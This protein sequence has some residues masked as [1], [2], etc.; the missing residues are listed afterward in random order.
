MNPRLGAQVTVREFAFDFERGA[1]DSRAFAGLQVGDFSLETAPLGPSQIHA[2]EH[3][4]PILRLHPASARMNR[5][6]RAEAIELAAEHYLELALAKFFAR[7]VKRGRRLARSLAVFLAVLAAFGGGF[8]G[9]YLKEKAR[10]LEA[11]GQTLKRRE[12]LANLILLAQ[13]GLREFGTI[14]EIWSAGLF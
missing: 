1:L 7:G 6:D 14:P 8:F 3:L 9:R 11:L 2:Q 4:G 10:F 12:A 5:Y 13:C